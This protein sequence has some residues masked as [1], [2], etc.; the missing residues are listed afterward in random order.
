[1][2]LSPKSDALAPPRLT[3]SVL[4]AIGKGKM[5]DYEI[6][7]TNAGNINACGFCG[8]KPGRTEGAS[9]ESG[10]AQGALRGNSGDAFNPVRHSVCSATGTKRRRKNSCEYFPF[11]SCATPGACLHC[12]A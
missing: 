7:D 1:M 10:L 4:Q 5:G 11:Y 9:P 8:Y 3:T 12:Q 6:V 2:P